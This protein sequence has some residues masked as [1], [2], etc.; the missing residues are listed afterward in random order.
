MSNIAFFQ[1]RLGRTDG[2]SLEV[3]KWKKIL[4]EKLGHKVWYCS[5]NDDVVGNYV[6]PELYAAHPTTQKI[7][8]NASRTF[9]D[10]K[11][12]A[13]MEL[14][15]YNHAEIMEKKLLEFIDKYE[16]DILIPNNLCSGGFQPAA[17]IA[18]HNVIRKTGLP[19]IIHSHDFY[20]ESEQSKEVF[21]TCY[22]AKSIYNRYFPTNLPNV[23]HVVI[24]K[25]SQQW[26]K[27]HK[28]M[29]AMVVP[30]VFDFEQPQWT[31]DSYN[32]DFRQSLNISQDD[33]VF[34][35]ATRIL[36]RKGIELAIDLVQKIDHTPQLR[37]KLIGV[38]T[39]LGGTFKKESKIILLCAGIVETIGISGSYWENLQEKAR[40]QQ[41]DLRYCGD[42]VK[43]SRETGTSGEKIYSLW[44]S[45]V[46]SDFV[47]YP[48]IWEGWGNQLIE[49]IFSKLPFVV[50]EYPVFTSDLAQA[51]F[52]CATLGSQCII[53]D[54]GL[55]SVDEKALILAA[56]QTVNTLAD[57]TQRTA[58][59][60]HNFE[61]AK[62]R[63]SYDQLEDC[64]VRLLKNQSFSEKKQ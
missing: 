29:D 26:L 12:E 11:T 4:T 36:D 63:Y 14:E 49:A 37:D 28:N 53:N 5:G 9:V 6:I 38:N 31:L 44:D 41:V 48:S 22:T 16:I 60:E 13:E 54:N 25:L 33:L 3:D 32:Q 24:N 45:Y 57:I 34:L 23:Q 43:H 2:V 42:M 52:A 18:F 55:V 64:I 51:N 21:P 19:T 46:N 30:N 7:L 39:A 8:K 61:I 17:A 27:E 59:V 20:F 35:Q 40:L 56:E 1:N 50:Y 15:I 10:Y 58:N 62:Q 47:T